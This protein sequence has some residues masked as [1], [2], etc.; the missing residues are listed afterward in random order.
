M[1]TRPSEQESL[2]HA[3]IG[4]NSLGRVALHAQT[5]SHPAGLGL[6]P[7]LRSIDKRKQ[8][9]RLSRELQERNRAFSR[10]GAFILGAKRFF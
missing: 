5:S 3:A 7:S 1:E 6:R 2:A 8:K 4:F 10:V 9:G